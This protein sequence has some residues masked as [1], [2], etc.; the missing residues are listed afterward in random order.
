MNKLLLDEYHLLISPTLA[1]CI[2]LNE[3]IVIQQLHCW[4]CNPNVG[5]TVDG[6]KWIKN[7]IEQW[8]RGNF[9]FLSLA[10][11]R[12]TFFELRD[13]NLVLVRGDLNSNRMDRALW[14]SIHYANLRNVMDQADHIH[15]IDLLHP[16][17]ETTEEPV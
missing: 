16:L 17:T 14:Y 5:E 10:T 4:I 15:L 11:V 3:A 9:P 6:K 13:R 7:S 1:A 8:Q 2:G 12:R